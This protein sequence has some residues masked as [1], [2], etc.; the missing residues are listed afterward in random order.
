MSF[1]FKNGAIFF[2]ADS[3]MVKSGIFS[4]STGVGTVIINILESEISSGLAVKYTFEFFI[5]VSEIS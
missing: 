4:S 5:K 2:E 1:F 3:N